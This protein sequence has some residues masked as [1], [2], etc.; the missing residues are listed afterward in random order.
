M[1]QL[2]A[3]ASALLLIPSAAHA[4]SSAAPD[5]NTIY[6]DCTKPTSEAHCMSYVFGA[7]EGIALVEK[8]TLPMEKRTFCP[9]NGVT[10]PQMLDVVLAYMKANPKLRH[11]RSIMLV[12]QAL[13]DAFP[14]PQK[15]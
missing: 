9:A 13:A 15:E 14:C 5:G 6:D 8:S 3:L 11:H 2:I 10:G 1:N 12:H 7:A 4:Q